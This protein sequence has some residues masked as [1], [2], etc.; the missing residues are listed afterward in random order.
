MCLESLRDTRV[1]VWFVLGTRD[2]NKS[3][4][5]HFEQLYM[6][7]V[8]LKYLLSTKQGAKQQGI[9]SICISAYQQLTAIPQIKDPAQSSL[10]QPAET[11]AWLDRIC[12][13]GH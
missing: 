4:V 12:Y 2:E 13:L 9:R 8:C 11:P 3:G 10:Q 7:V 1:Y 5:G 6:L